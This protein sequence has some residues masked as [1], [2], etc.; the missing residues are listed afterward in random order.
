[1]AEFAMLAS[2]WVGPVL[3]CRGEEGGNSL[4]LCC[5]STVLFLHARLTMVLCATEEEEESQTCP[6]Y[7]PIC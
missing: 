5:N 6:G 1:M 2:T 3:F 4:H 7:G